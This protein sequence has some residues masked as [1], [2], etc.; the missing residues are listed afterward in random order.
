MREGPADL[1]HG[2]LQHTKQNEDEHVRNE[3]RLRRVAIDTRDG[4]V[5]DDDDDDGGGVGLIANATRLRTL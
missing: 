4:T 5:G 2:S 1:E 3:W